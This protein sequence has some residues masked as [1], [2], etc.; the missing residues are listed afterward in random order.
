MV[1]E[2]SHTLPRGSER[3]EI[4]DFAPSFYGKP[5][6]GWNLTQFGASWVWRAVE[7][8]TVNH[9]KIRDFEHLDCFQF[10][11]WP[12]Q[13]ALGTC[14]QPALMITVTTEGTTRFLCIVKYPKIQRHRVCISSVATVS[15]IRKYSSQRKS[16]T[17]YVYFCTYGTCMQEWMLILMLWSLVL[18]NPTSFETHSVEAFSKP[19]TGFG[20]RLVKTGLKPIGQLIR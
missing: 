4:L 8:A 14:N 13:A 19:A 10:W 17:W 9:D 18:E 11:L 5:R 2:T 16:S 6:L 20:W 15:Q 1:H 3:W 7:S 12:C